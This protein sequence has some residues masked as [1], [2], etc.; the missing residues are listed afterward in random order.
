MLRIEIIDDEC[1]E[2]EAYTFSVPFDTPWE[3]IKKAVG[4]FYP[5]ATC[6]SI[7]VVEE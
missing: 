7:I 5:D 3:D 4:L 1:K 6:V 2:G